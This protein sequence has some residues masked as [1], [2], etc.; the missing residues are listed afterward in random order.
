MMKSNVENT[1]VGLF[2]LLKHIWNVVL[3]NGYIFVATD[4]DIVIFEAGISARNNN[5]VLLDAQTL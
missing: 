5:M 1:S 3:Q 4:C 2:V